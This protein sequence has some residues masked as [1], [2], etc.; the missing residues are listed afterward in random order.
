MSSSTSNA[1]GP[2]PAASGAS[3]PEQAPIVAAI[4][5]QFALLAHELQLMIWHEACRNPAPRIVTDVDWRWRILGEKV[6]A[7]LITCVMSRQV[8]LE[9]YRKY[10]LQIMPQTPSPWLNVDTD[11]YYMMT[12]KTYFFDHFHEMRH[13][14]YL[15]LHQ[16]RYHRALRDGDMEEVEKDLEFE[17]MASAFPKLETITVFHV[18]L[19][20]IHYA[21]KYNLA[22]N[23]MKR[24]TDFKNLFGTYS[25]GCQ[26]GCISWPEGVEVEEKSLE[27]L[28]R[29]IG[30]DPHDWSFF[31]QDA[32]MD[33]DDFLDG[34]DDFS[35]TNDKFLHFDEDTISFT[36]IGE[37]PVRILK[38]LLEQEGETRIH[39]FDVQVD[40]EKQ[41]T[42]SRLMPPPHLQFASD[43]NKGTKPRKL[44]EC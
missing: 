23:P 44:T 39:C 5:P 7:V 4:F 40:K 25:M 32:L 17:G 24:R 19:L 29:E 13:I 36:M 33:R 15:A 37:I 9:Y 16:G 26:L 21:A 35:H 43:G 28:L 20:D 38:E 18:D 42:A 30:E 34:F 2:G 6:P 3:V 12:F 14:A 31:F 41:L 11:I 22:L 27:P 10:T 1:S 8:A